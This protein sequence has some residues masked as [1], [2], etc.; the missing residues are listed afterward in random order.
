MER[1]TSVIDP[2]TAEP[3]VAPSIGDAVGDR[4]VASPADQPI[5]C[6][7][8]RQRCVE[9]TL[10]ALTRQLGSVLAE[11]S[12][13]REFFSTSAGRAFAR[14][15]VGPGCDPPGA[16][17]GRRLDPRRADR[18]GPARQHLERP[19]VGDRSVERE[20]RP[21]AGLALRRDRPSARAGVRCDRRR[22]RRARP[23]DDRPGERAP[24]VRR[25]SASSRSCWRP[26]RASSPTVGGIAATW[27][28]G[29]RWTS[30]SPTVSIPRAAMAALVIVHRGRGARSG[31]AAS[32][33][34]AR[35]VDL[36]GRPRRTRP[37]P[38]RW[39]CS[40]NSGVVPT[41]LARGIVSEFLASPLDP[42]VMGRPE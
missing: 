11:V 21:W 1:T 39:P 38:R 5:D 37:W 34:P 35:L 10:T 23:V 19:L 25:G 6:R 17:A 22:A 41:E 28:S 13:V 2:E 15:A 40:A 16:A 9:R 8:E 42:R 31:Q 14:L 20:C 4:R 12:S 33:S 7:A 27:S 29:W 24:G 18:P 30:S 26:T 3:W 32:S 36:R